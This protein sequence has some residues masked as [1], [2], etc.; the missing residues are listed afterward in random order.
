MWVAVMYRTLF[1]SKHS[2]API[3]DLSRRSLA[4]ARRS[5]R[6]RSK[7]TRFSQSTAIVTYVG[8]AINISLENRS[9]VRGQIA[10]VRTIIRRF[11]PLQSDLLPLTS[12]TATE[13][14]RGLKHGLFGRYGHIFQRR[15][16]RN[17]NMHR[18][19]A[20]DGSVQIVECAGRDH[21]RKFGGDAVAFVTFVEDDR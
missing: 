3:S 14:T 8:R 16:E 1:M 2:S 6:R 20:F 4:R 21:G 5:R 19:H 17:W 13:C 9:E 12:F 10:E 15:R 18:A 7:S 11:S